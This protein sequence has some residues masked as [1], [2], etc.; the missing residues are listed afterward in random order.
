VGYDQKKMEMFKIDKGH[1]SP[2]ARER[3]GKGKS[4]GI[5][6]LGGQGLRGVGGRACGSSARPPRAATVP[7]AAEG[8]RRAM[9]SGSPRLEGLRRW[10]RKRA[11]STWGRDKAPKGATQKDEIGSGKG[12]QRKKHDVSW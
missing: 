1:V 5:F 12:G 8:R 4:H 7:K 3:E 10:S 2:R 9:R 6:V 11:L